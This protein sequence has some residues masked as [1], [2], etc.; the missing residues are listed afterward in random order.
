MN[1][2]N[3]IIN[4]VSR[5]LTPVKINRFDTRIQRSE[6]EYNDFLLRVILETKQAIKRKEYVSILVTDQTYSNILNGIKKYRDE[7]K[8]K[9]G[10]SLEYMVTRNKLGDSYI[11]IVPKYKLFK[12]F[13]EQLK[14]DEFLMSG[15]EC[16]ST[17]WNF[18]H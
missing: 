13:F 3:R 18:F 5:V 12:Y 4:K 14:A 1:I 9:E 2:F 6:S 16:T 8:E 17:Y 7:T 10:D 15:K 11:L